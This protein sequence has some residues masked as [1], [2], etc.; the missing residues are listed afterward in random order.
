M[1]KINRKL[2]YA[3]M[4]LKYMDAKH[5]GE[6]TS[7]KEICD[8]HKAP[9]DVTARVLQV[10]SQQGIVK[11][12][13]GSH[14][15]YQIIKDLAKMSLLELTEVILGPV[16]FADCLHEDAAGCAMTAD[17]NVISPIMH[18]NERLKHLYTDI[19]IRELIGVQ[20]PGEKKVRVNSG[21]QTFVV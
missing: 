17:C 16:Q 12:E 14:G 20:H 8:R 4:A 21:N 6:L 10:L 13:H 5:P 9:F 1:F 11:A 3:L 15:G 19:S 18:L 2:E 7:V